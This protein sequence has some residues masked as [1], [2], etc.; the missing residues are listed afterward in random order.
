MTRISRVA[1]VLALA[2]AVALPAAAATYGKGV[3]LKETTKISDIY[4]NPDKYVGKA[5]KV[6]GTI[7]DVCSKRG[8]WMLIGSDK[9]FQTIRF[10]VEDGVIVIPMEAKGKKGVAEG[11]LKKIEMTKEEA[12]AY[13][14]HIAEEN[15]RTFDP[16]S[17]TGP[18]V[19]FQLQGTG[20][21]I[22]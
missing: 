20:A 22:D 7:T 9:E 16:K 21:V 17:V 13:D 4:A 2:L 10:K 5:V 12:I 14:K 18:R 6:E 3:T 11:T 19:L 1:L 15:G 8:C